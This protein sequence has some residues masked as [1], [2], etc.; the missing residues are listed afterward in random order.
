M[1]ELLFQCL[2]TTL[3]VTIVSILL[4][5][6]TCIERTTWYKKAV[7]EISEFLTGESTDFYT[8]YNE[9]ITEKP[10]TNTK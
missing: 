4:I 6:T 9:Q 5:V 7:S 3:F 2:D 8:K 10:F 1:K